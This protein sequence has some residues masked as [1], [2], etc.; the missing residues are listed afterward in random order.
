MYSCSWQPHPTTVGRQ[1]EGHGIRMVITL[2]LEGFPLNGWLFGWVCFLP[3]HVARAAR[4]T[5]ARQVRVGH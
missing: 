1:R 2:I 5:T 4:P 3:A